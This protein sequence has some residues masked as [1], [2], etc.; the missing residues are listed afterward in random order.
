VNDPDTSPHRRG[1]PEGH[2]PILRFLGVPLHDS[3]KVV[4]LIGLANKDS[5]FT[6][7]DRACI[8]ALAPAFVEALKRKRAEMER[9]R[10]FLELRDALEN[11]RT[12]QG[13]L[14]ICSSCKKIRDD[15]GYWTQLEVYFSDHSDAQ[16]S[17]GLCPECAE[18]MMKEFEKMKL[19]DLS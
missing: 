3:E 19:E 8:E 12:L 6:E 15:K 9:E 11:V 10:L 7:H 18:K 14:P 4:G 17:H 13:L 1:V 2:V 5:D 16:F